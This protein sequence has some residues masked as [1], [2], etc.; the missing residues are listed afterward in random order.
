[1]KI[2]KNS[3]ILNYPKEDKVKQ[4][5][6]LI[7]IAKFQTKPMWFKNWIMQSINKQD[8]LVSI[9]NNQRLGWNIK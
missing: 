4:K 7:W 9:K 5:N 2:C 1:M 6:W 8:K 3:L